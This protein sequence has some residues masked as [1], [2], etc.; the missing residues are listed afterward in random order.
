M[1]DGHYIARWGFTYKLDTR[2]NP[3]AVLSK[4]AADDNGTP[5]AA[6]D[7][8]GKKATTEE[9]DNKFVA[10]QVMAPDSPPKKKTIAAKIQVKPSIQN[11]QL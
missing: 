8:E 11:N 3:T 7:K 6:V 1:R 9:E 4:I 5:P 2:Q 10:E